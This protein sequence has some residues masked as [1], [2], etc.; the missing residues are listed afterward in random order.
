MP[1]FGC[2]SVAHLFIN[3]RYCPFVLREQAPRVRTSPP[4]LPPY[5]RV[6]LPLYLQCLF[7]VVAVNLTVAASDQM[8]G[9]NNK[10]KKGLE[11]PRGLW[12]TDHPGAYASWL[13][14]CFDMAIAESV[15]PTRKTTTRSGTRT[16]WASTT[17]ANSRRT[18]SPARGTKTTE[19]SAMLGK[20][21]G[22]TS[23]SCRILQRTCTTEKLFEQRREGKRHLYSFNRS[24]KIF[25]PS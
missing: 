5:S 15:G 3:T 19:C 6:T 12:L 20:R 1:C 11:L 16:L 17:C 9:K 4:G 18:W 23:N 21:W 13:S 10:E 22:L 8:S 25:F 2:R 24:Y 7:F 14:S